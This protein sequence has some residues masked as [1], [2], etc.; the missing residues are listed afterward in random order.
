[1]K[2]HL[3]FAIACLTLAITLSSVGRAEPVAPPALVGEAQEWTEESVQLVLKELHVPEHLRRKTVWEYLSRKL[4]LSKG[5]QMATE[6]LAETE[7]SLGQFEAV[8]LTFGTA[9]ALPIA[10]A[11]AGGASIAYTVCENGLT[12]DCKEVGEF[13]SEKLY[14]LLNKQKPTTANAHSAVARTAQTR[15]S[16]NATLAARSSVAGGAPTAASNTPSSSTR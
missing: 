16:S 13:W 8:E 14:N 12:P 10:L 7:A 1:M 11:V 9:A 5:G 2:N 3:N 15:T 4:T 6:S